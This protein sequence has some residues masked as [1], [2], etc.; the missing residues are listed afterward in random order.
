MQHKIPKEVL[1]KVYNEEKDADVSKRILLVL[2]VKYDGMKPIRAS[3]ELYRDRS[4]AT[5][6]L[7]RFESDG[8]DGLKTG[9]RSGRPPKVQSSV[10]KRVERR[11]MGCQGGWRVREIRELIHNESGVMYS[12]RQV[13]RLMHRWG[14]RRVV[15]QKRFV[16]K[17]S[18]EEILSFKKGREGS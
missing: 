16:N 1:E 4:W 3:R 6:W 18:R 10:V 13:Y 8:L 5:I 7:R 14:L 17:A 12:E 2:K 11:V 15:P 9:E